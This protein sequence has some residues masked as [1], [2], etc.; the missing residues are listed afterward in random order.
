MKTFETKRDFKEII[1][2]EL[3]STSGGIL[4]GSILA[5]AI[6]RVELIPGLFILLP[7]FLEMRGNISGSLSARL[8]SALFLGV[9]KPK[10]ERNRILWGNILAS[11]ALVFIVSLALGSVAYF[12]DLII[13][14]VNDIGVILL[15]LIAAFISNLFEIPITV[16]FTFWLFR[17]NYDPNDIMGPYV[18][19]TGDITSIVSLLIG[20]VL[21]GSWL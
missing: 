7:G 3:I 17:H 19:T 4:A 20:L 1:T 14:G 15:I 2:S 6:N 21:V 11:T 18:T 8:S 5:F 16:Y 10:V 13:F 12:L 9:I